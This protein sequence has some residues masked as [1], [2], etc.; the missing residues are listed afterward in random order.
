MIADGMKRKLKK[1]E[2]NFWPSLRYGRSPSAST[3][4][5]LEIKC[6]LGSQFLLGRITAPAFLISAL[7]FG[8]IL[9]LVPS[10][11]A[12]SSSILI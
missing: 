1:I 7:E 8:E 10:L 3:W 6:V 11:H 5:P 2:Y 9:S 12:G 4:A